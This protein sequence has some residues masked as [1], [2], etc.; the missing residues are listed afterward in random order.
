MSVMERDPRL[1]SLQDQPLRF[2]SRV[3]PNARFRLHLYDAEPPPANARVPKSLLTVLYHPVE[4]LVLSIMQAFSQPPLMS[5][6]YY[7]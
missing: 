3:N 4:P 7:D 5:V 2:A 1:H 6:S